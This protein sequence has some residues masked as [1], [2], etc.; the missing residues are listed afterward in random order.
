[1]PSNKQPF[2]LEIKKYKVNFIVI[3]RCVILF[4]RYSPRADDEFGEGILGN[5]EFQKMYYLNV[6]ESGIDSR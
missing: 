5:Q 6:S 2:L 3:S 4:I 1:V